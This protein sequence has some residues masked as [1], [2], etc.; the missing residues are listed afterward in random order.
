[1]GSFLQRIF[2]RSL[3]SVAPVPDL[4]ALEVDMHSHLLPGLDD[5]AEALE[6]SVELVR[7]MQELGYRKLVMTP[8]VMGDFYKNTPAAIQAALVG[9]REAVAIAGITDIELAC[10]AEYYLDEW[11]VQKLENGEELLSFGGA[12]RYVLIE[13]SYINEP[14]NFQE[15]IFQLKSAG[16]QPVL[17]HPERYT[18]LYDNFPAL[19]KMRANDIL[20]QVNL[21][22]LAG[23]YSRGAKRVAE[24][25]IDAGLVDL[26]G[27]DAH[28]LK[29][30]ATLREKVLSAEYLRKALALPLLNSSL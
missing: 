30:T 10:A 7:A 24:K 11:F 3:A 25:L 21:N 13:T 29:H 5:G 9:L 20:L 17:A 14:F 19:E 22:S 15:I 1:M 8:H 27:T 12:K 16:Y 23:Y 26:L 18:F 4:A 28:N 2:G 6:Q